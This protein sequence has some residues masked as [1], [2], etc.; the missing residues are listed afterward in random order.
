MSLTEIIKLK[1]N[2]SQLQKMNQLILE[3]K[4]NWNTI[5]EAIKAGCEIGRR[6]GNDLEVEKAM[7]IKENLFKTVYDFTDIMKSIAS[8]ET[9]PSWREFRRQADIFTLRILNL[10]DEIKDIID[11]NPSIIAWVKSAD[12]EEVMEEGA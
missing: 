9:R 3:R 4:E 2:V 6:R 12:E 1:W 5:Q 7:A 8:D 11:N 10:A